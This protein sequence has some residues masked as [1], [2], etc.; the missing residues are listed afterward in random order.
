MAGE[1]NQMAPA[2]AR[3]ARPALVTVLGVIFIVFGALVLLTFPFLVLQFAG[4]LPGM[5]QTWL[6]LDDPFYYGLSALSLVTVPLVGLAEI[7]GGAG[8]L[9]L[10]SGARNLLIA[11]LIFGIVMALTTIPVTVNAF[12]SPIADR[13]FGNTRQMQVAKDMGLVTTI[14]GSVFSVVVNGVFLMLITSP[15][16]KRA[17]A[18]AAPARC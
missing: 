8:L 17:F 9:K 2:A 15:T 14:V 12:N 6:P 10:R 4:A 1:V 5:E 13:A 11:V 16:V 7:F 3:P 18:A